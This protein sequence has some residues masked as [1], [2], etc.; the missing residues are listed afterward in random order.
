MTL[1]PSASRRNHRVHLRLWAMTL[2]VS[3][4]PLSARISSG[5]KFSF[6]VHCERYKCGLPWRQVSTRRGLAG[7]HR[8]QLNHSGS[9]KINPGPDGPRLAVRAYELKWFFSREASLLSC[10]PATDGG[11][12]C[13]AG[14]EQ[15]HFSA[16]HGKQIGA[17]LMPRNR[18]DNAGRRAS[19][20][21]AA[22]VG[23]TSA[24]IAGIVQHQT[25]SRCRNRKLSQRRGSPHTGVVEI[26]AVKASKNSTD[27]QLSIARLQSIQYK[28]VENT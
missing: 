17:G 5:H 7:D 28:T 25:S 18:T 26:V 10:V 22:K 3:K 20:V 23:R 9:P 13:V 19:A 16:G 14:S 21:T 1:R 12:R 24:S 2:C 8:M 27:P 6:A 4:M 15:G 11:K